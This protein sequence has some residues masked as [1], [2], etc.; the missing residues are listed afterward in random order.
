MSTAWTLFWI[1][2]IIIVI[3]IFFWFLLTLG[4]DDA[5]ETDIN[6]ANI[7]QTCNTNNDCKNNLLCDPNTKTCKIPQGTSC[8]TT[9]QCLQGQV[10][11]T[12]CKPSSATQGG[13]G[14]ATLGQPCI[15]GSCQIGLICKNNICN[16]P[17]L[18]DPCSVG[19]ASGNGDCIAD[20]CTILVGFNNAC[21][22]DVLCSPSENLLCVSDNGGVHRCK[23]KDDR[24]CNSDDD[25]VSRNCSNKTCVSSANNLVSNNL[26]VNN[27]ISNNLIACS[28]NN[29]CPQGS[30]QNSAIF[31]INNDGSVFATNM[32]TNVQIIDVIAEGPNNTIVLL[33]DGNIIRYMN[34]SSEVI[35]NNIKLQQLAFLGRIED[36]TLQVYGL[37]NGTVYQ[38]DVENSTPTNWQ[39]T[40]A[41]FA[42]PNV[43]HISNSHDGQTLWIQATV[44]NQQIGRLYRISTGDPQLV[45]ETVL[46]A[47]TKRVYGPNGDTFIDVSLS[48]VV[49]QPQNIVVADYHKGVILV[50]GRTIRISKNLSTTVTEVKVVNGTPFVIVGRVCTSADETATI[51]ANNISII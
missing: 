31:G 37:S 11:E 26:L 5:P 29:D 30:C 36:N 34:G 7:G 15:Q 32:S 43:T 27:L 1:I 28:N 47:D 18:G 19:C 35:K 38:L 40:V 51:L 39:W 45:I 14:T 16:L 22:P 8:E 3:I 49:I 24:S 20:V 23:Y 13:L 44:G 4:R 17:T 25:C 42:P 48:R 10:C 50:D 41:E 9:S 12:T 33:V 21:G 46:S 6:K 2:L